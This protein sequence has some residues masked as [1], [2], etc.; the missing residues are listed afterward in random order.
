MGLFTRKHYDNI[1][2]QSRTHPILIVCKRKIQRFSSTAVSAHLQRRLTTSRI[3]EM[4]LNVLTSVT[5][6]PTMLIPSCPNPWDRHFIHFVRICI[7][8]HIC[9]RHSSVRVFLIID[10]KSIETLDKI[11][12]KVFVDEIN[13][14]KWKPFCYKHPKIVLNK[15]VFGWIFHYRNMITNADVIWYFW[16]HFIK[17]P[18][19]IW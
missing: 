4:I 13:N 7:Y 16:A 12:K 6:I 9:W 14:L 17:V 10:S 5:T 19:P 1:K 11:K 2:P 3:S 18:I 15:Q 8:A